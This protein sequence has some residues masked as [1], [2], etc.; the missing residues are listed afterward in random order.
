MSEDL[1]WFVVL[2]GVENVTTASATLRMSQPALSR[3]LARLENELGTQ[4]F[5]RHGRRL[6]L[7]ESGSIL[8]EHSRRALA[9]LDSAERRIADVASGSTAVRLGFLHSLGTWLVPTLIKEF[10]VTA[11]HVRFE[12]FQDAADVLVSR[13][14]DGLSDVALVSP[15]PRRTDLRWTVVA[16]QALAIAVPDTHSR[17]T[18]RAAFL[19]DFRKESFITLQADFGMRRIFDEQCAAAGFSPRIVF[20]ASELA[21]VAGLVAAGLGVALLPVQASEPGPS[22][23]SLIPL[24][25]AVTTREIGFVQSS[26]RTASN[27]TKQFT[28]FAE[29]SQ[30]L[31]HL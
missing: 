2:A 28:S 13:V 8:L 22:G 14:V 7:S 21:T 17:A 3:R 26:S 10:R 27:A 15:R 19:A 5:V 6:E 18:D 24:K 31:K 1:R 23:L 20:E 30:S 11:P 25:S 12:L 16:E 4:L 29:I 9:D